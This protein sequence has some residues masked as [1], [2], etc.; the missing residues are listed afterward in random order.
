MNSQDS[1]YA[2]I[3]LTV[4]T[5]LHVVLNRTMFAKLSNLEK[6]RVVAVLALKIIK[7]FHYEF[8]F[9]V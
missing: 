7:D 9:H 6:H 8:P 2:Y 1:A 5:A 3:G 4:D